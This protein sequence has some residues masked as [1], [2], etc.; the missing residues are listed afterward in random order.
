MSRDLVW[1]KDFREYDDFSRYILD[2]DSLIDVPKIKGV[3][4][5]VSKKKRFRVGQKLNENENRF[6]H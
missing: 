2:I 6:L 4:I 3:Y 5:F 1:I